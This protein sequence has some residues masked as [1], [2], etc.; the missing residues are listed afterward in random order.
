[1]KADYLL[2]FINSVV[3]EF[4]KGE[5]CGDESFIIPPSLCEITKRFISIAGHILES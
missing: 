3:N 1:M 2:H 5:G 4:Q